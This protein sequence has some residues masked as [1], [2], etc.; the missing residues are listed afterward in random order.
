MA[1]RRHRRQR[2]RRPRPA[3][4]L[5][6]FLFLGAFAVGLFLIWVAA[7]ERHEA[8]KEKAKQPKLTMEQARAANAAIP[9]ADLKPRPARPFYF[10]GNTASREQATQCLAT[11]ALYEAGSDER[12]QRAVIQVVLN[13]VRRAGFPKT[14]CGVVYQGA[15]RTTGCQFSFSCDG[16]RARRPEHA[17]WAA[18]RHAAQRA[19]SGYVFRPVGT[20]THYH[21]DWIVPYWIGS[22]DKIA[23]VKSH[24]FYR[25]RG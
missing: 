6:P 19:L 4:P 5:S 7:H 10:R 21:T 1:P 25:P 22:L 24:I 2:R 12:G 15:T 9:F 11:A 13:R 17:G 23:K 3:T 16:S 20:A 14:V 8:K 18:A